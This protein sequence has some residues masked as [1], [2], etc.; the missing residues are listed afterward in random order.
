MKQWTT[1]VLVAL[2]LATAVMG[3]EFQERAKKVQ[4]LYKAG[5]QAVEDGE[6]NAARAAFTEVL[7]IN[8]NHGHARYQLGQLKA[9]HSRVMM[10]RR[11][12]LF[13]KTKIEKIDFNGA[14]L[15]EALNDLNYLT[16]KATDKKFVPNFVIQDPKGK[17]KDVKITL[18]LGK[19]PLAAALK[20]T[21]EQAGAS[22]RYDS[23][24]TI[25]TPRARVRVD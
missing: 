23:H 16:A 7:S 20:Y 8:P 2:S 25:I 5:L 14:T 18:T 1:T 19:V 9:N 15:A 17:L 3:N 13:K 12:A 10:A 22:V 24:A 21:L 6:I 11:K 4:G